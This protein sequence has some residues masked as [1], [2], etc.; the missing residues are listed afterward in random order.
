MTKATTT[1]TTTTTNEYAV[2]NFNGILYVSTGILKNTRHSNHHHGESNLAG[3][4]SSSFN[5]TDEIGK[6]DSLGPT[7]FCRADSSKLV[8][9]ESLACKINSWES[10]PV[11]NPIPKIK[12]NRYKYIDS[13]TPTTI[14]SLFRVSEQKRNACVETFL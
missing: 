9:H 1:T 7:T 8:L 12:V 3:V 10:L 5:E 13:L 14:L 11:S 6:T 2:C 4:I